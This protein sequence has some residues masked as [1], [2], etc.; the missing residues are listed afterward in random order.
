MSGPR[1]FVHFAAQTPE[2]A[3]E[4]VETKHGSAPLALTLYQAPDGSTIYGSAEIHPPVDD[5]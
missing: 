5:E 2:H 1:Y 3:F 4:F